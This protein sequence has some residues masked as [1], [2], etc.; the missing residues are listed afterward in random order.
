MPVTYLSFAN[1]R[2]V[3]FTNSHHTPLPDGNILQP[4]QINIIS[5]P[6]GSGKS[7]VLDILRT[8]S[9][10][11]KLVSLGRENMR[12]DT[13]GFFRLE[14][15]NNTILVALFTSQGIGKSHV[16]VMAKH[17][18]GELIHEDII[19]SHSSQPFPSGY[20]QCMK[21]LQQNVAYRSGHDITGLS[22]EKVVMYLNKDARYLPGTAASGLKENAFRYQRPPGQQS[23][24]EY[25][26]EH[27]FSVSDSGPDALDVWLHDDELQSNIITIEDIPAGWKAFAG[28]LTWLSQQAPL[29]ICVIE[30]P[31]VHIHPQLQRILVKRI[32]EI[33]AEKCLQLFISTHSTVFLEYG[34]WDNIPVS[35]YEADG[36]GVKDFTRS[37]AFLSAMGMR[38]SEIFQANG[39]IWVEGVSDRIYIRHWLKLYCEENGLD[40]PIENVHY[41][42]IPYGGAM[43]KHYSAES[44]NT[45]QA[46]MIN[47]NCIFIADCDNDY[48][49]TTLANPILLSAKTAKEAIRQNLPTW[50]TQGYTIEN[51]LPEPVLS[52]FFD[53]TAD[54]TSL[55]NGKAKMD[56]AAYFENTVSEFK[57]SYNPNLNL[58]EMIEFIINHISAWNR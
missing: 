34:I 25:I 26:L 6:N 2:K 17:S 55:K 32:K 20:A 46:L 5:G 24:S 54:K 29:T 42:F 27:C 58:P 48:D 21:A 13:T 8:I 38:P 45:I 37:A 9:N 40:T 35:L 7:T 31:E 15:D 3:A 39:V 51:Y 4:A 52:T 23:F 14:F 10:P 36:Y 56:V 41:A 57:G 18:T 28:L 19:S 47:K 53:V 33:T 22:L 1:L 44:A 16:G 11:T 43:L 30:E 50:I 49:M 12:S